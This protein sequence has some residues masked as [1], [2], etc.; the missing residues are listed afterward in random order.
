MR[1]EANS[2]YPFQ[3]ITIIENSYRRKKFVEYYLCKL[4]DDPRNLSSDLLKSNLIF[5]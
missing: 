5:P 1:L 3:E 4:R 2:L